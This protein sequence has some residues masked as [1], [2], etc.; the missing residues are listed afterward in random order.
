MTQE[1]AWLENLWSLLKR[2]LNGTHVSA[3]PFD[4]SRHLDEQSF[5][6]NERKDENGDARRFRWSC[7]IAVGK[8]DVQAVDR[9]GAVD[10]FRNREFD[11][12]PSNG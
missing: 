6:C 9:E 12:R 1:T 2:P 4:L 7:E 5:R 3:E 11:C 8:A 10:G